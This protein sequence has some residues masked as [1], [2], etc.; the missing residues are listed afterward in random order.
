MRALVVDDD[1]AW[2]QI[3]AELLVDAGLTVDVAAD[4]RA[5]VASLRLNPHRLAVVD[6]SLG[7]SDHRNEDGLAVLDAVRRHDPG[8]ATI[9]LSGFATVELA[10][11]AL[12]E[13]GAHTCLR[14]ERFRRAEFRKVVQEVLAL[15]LAPGYG[16]SLETHPV[17]GAPS[18]V[19]T[20]A[21]ST[22]TVMVVEDD[23]GWRSILAEL[24]TDAGYQVRLASSYGEAFGHLKRGA[25]TLAVVDLSLT[26]AMA[27]DQSEEGYRLLA[28]SR[29]LGIPAVVVTGSARAPD[30]ERAWDDYGIV[31]FLEK[32]TFDRRA[33]V[34]SVAEALA[35]PPAVPSSLDALTGR[36]R[37]VLDLLVQ[38]L[39]NKQIADRL[40]ISPN[41]VKRHLKA[42]FA[43]LEVNTRAAAVAK[44]MGD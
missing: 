16:G 1:R 18:G 38:G 20:A 17:V 27:G 5:A 23:A 21:A 19:S 32:R 2:Q 30:A 10:V 4:L 25:C 39:T 14:K 35:K 34:A 12:K 6:L 7:G 24:L 44:A 40:V 8:C 22:V 36:E 29:Q 31:A 15:P 42:V 13:H 28:A 41:T 37:E 9:L 26:G 11:A 3:L 33:F 43:K